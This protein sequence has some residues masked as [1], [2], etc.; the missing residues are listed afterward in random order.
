LATFGIPDYYA[1]ALDIYVSDYRAAG[2]MVLEELAS[3]L[4]RA[5]TG[6]KDRET[7]AH[8]RECQRLVLR[9]LRAD[10]TPSAKTAP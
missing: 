10:E 5:E 6:I 1:T 8:F 7:L 3:R 4:K 9:A 2:F